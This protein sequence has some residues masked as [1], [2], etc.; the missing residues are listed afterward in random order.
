MVDRFQSPVGR[1]R[2]RGRC[3]GKAGANGSTRISRVSIDVSKWKGRQWTGSRE[4]RV[5]LRVCACN[6]VHLHR[7]GRDVP[8]T[9][10]TPCIWMRIITKVM[11][12]SGIL[13]PGRVRTCNVFSRIRG[14]AKVQRPRYSGP[15]Y[16]MFNE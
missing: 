6:T 10:A 15:S 1:R 14:L 13:H 11:S 7:G 4:W 8:A 3:S 5:S 12:A 16:A 2:A 9:T